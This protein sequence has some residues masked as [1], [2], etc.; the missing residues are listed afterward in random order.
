MTPPTISV[1]ICTRDRPQELERCLRSLAAQTE[2][3]EELIVVDNKPEGDPAAAAAAQRHGARLVPEPRSGVSRARNAGATAAVGDVVAFVDDDA[4]PDPGWVAAYQEAFRDPRVNAATGRVVGLSSPNHAR[5]DLGPLP[6][7]FDRTDPHWFEQANFGAVGL[8]LNMAFRRHLF[9]DGFSFPEWLGV[10]SPIPGGDEHYA[11]F[12]VLKAGGLIVYAPSAVARHD[13][14]AEAEGWHRRDRR[15]LQAA[16]AYVV[17]L[18]IQERGY[19]RATIRYVIG[20]LRGEK[21]TWR[22]GQTTPPKYRLG[23][24][25]VAVVMAPW[26]YAASRLLR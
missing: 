3:A 20:A 11:F 22:A 1:V 4:V 19:R 14:A 2:P 24:V 25:A 26:R 17:A 5:E 12:D 15:I 6:R 10:G 16:V 8:G 7:R 18:L 13:D 23:D 21:R 9:E